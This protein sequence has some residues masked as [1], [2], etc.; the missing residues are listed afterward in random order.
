[1]KM[2]KSLQEAMKKAI[3]EMVEWPGKSVQ[4]FHHNDADGLSSGAILTRALEREG[5]GVHRFCLEKPYPEVLRKVFE[6]KGA[7]LVFA[8]FAGRIAPLISRLNQGRNLTLILDHH[9]A[10]AATDPRVHNLDPELFGLKGDRDIAAATTCFLFAKTLNPDNQDL[11][12]IAAVGAVGDKFFVK[13]RLVSENR[14][15]ALEAARQGRV[16]VR[17]HG[18]GE[19]YFL[20]SP[21]GEV[22]CDDLGVYLDVLGGA[23]YYQGGPE[24]GVRVLLDGVSKESDRMVAALQATKEKAFDREMARLQG[25]ALQ[26]TGHIQWFHVEERFSPMGV[27]MIGLFCEAVRSRDFIDPGKYIAGFQTVP[28]EIPG[29]GRIEFNQVKISMRVPSLLEREIREERAMGLN[30][31]LPEATSRLGGFSDACHRLTAATTVAIGKEEDLV[32]E[33]EEILDQWQG[34]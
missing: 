23:G 14:E 28:N 32:R 18:E 20:K 9:A 4:V 2:V 29:F 5:Y 8:D 33:M 34:S 10:E 27:K 13:G 6:Q 16:E 3:K 12:H 22:R 1:M 17:E 15:A 30:V 11:A 26:R 19:F 31:F 21:G 7:I 24:M 25:G